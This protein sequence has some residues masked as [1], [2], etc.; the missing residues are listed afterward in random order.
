MA[1]TPIG[2]RKKGGVA[3]TDN[4]DNVAEVLHRLRRAQ[5]QL[6]GVIAMVEAGR[7][8]QGHRHPAGRRVQGTRPRGF[9]DGRHRDARMR[10][11]NHRRQRPTDR[12]RTRATLPHPRLTPIHPP[13]PNKEP[14]M[15]FNQYYLD[16]LSHA[17]YLIG[18]ETTG[19]AVVVDPQRDVSE[20]I[21]DAEELGMTIELVIE[22][23]FH[24]DFLSGHL[25]LAEATGAKIV[26]SSVAKPEFD[27]MPVEDGERYSL[28]DVQLGS[29]TPRPHSRVAEHRDL[30]ACRRRRAVR[31]ADR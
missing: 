24:A 29:G 28:G 13:E 16:C 6:G 21:A 17:S 20:Y 2:M 11:R 18:D 8:L 1:Y 3:M 9:Q 19:R 14:K 25:E 26:Y 4:D 31:G 23:H 12:G 5:G 10:D 30:R 22:T 7:P 15:K 27:F